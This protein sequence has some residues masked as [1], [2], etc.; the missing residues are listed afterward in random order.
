[1]V[2]ALL[3]LGLLAQSRLHNKTKRSL[4]AKRQAQSKG[5]YAWK[6]FLTLVCHIKSLCAR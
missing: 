3:G 4:T 5:G 2:S 1:M 6:T